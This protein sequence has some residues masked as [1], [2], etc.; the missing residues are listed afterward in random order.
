M[1]TEF[2][3]SN[4]GIL[5]SRMDIVGNGVHSSFECVDKICNSVYRIIFHA[6]VFYQIII[7]N[8]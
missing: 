2:S 7:E 5:I 8:V 3:I 6:V 1:F 4:Y